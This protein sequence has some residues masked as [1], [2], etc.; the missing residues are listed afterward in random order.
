MI[1]EKNA[2][3]KRKF[4]ARKYLVREIV[5]MKSLIE[6][7]DEIWNDLA[8]KSFVRRT[9]KKIEPTIADVTRDVVTYLRERARSLKDDT[10]ES[11][12]ERI[13][14]KKLLCILETIKHLDDLEEK[15]EEKKKR[16]IPK[17]EV[18]SSVITLPVKTPTPHQH[19]PGCGCLPPVPSLF[20]MARRRKEYRRKIKEEEEKKRKGKRK[21]Q[22]LDTASV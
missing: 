3:E 7:C 15:E 5:L 21:I 9:E 14:C 2:E 16:T 22:L 1:R 6:Q 12:R 20:E 4:Q 13:L 19:Y 8:N 17:V 18:T 11:A 10:V